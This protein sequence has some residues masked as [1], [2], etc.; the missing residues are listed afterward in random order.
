MIGMKIIEDRNTVESVEDWSRVRSPS[1][2]RRRLRYGHKQNIDIK[3]VPRK[4][5][6][7]IGDTLVMHP[8]MAAEMR[9]QLA[10]PTRGVSVETRKAETRVLVDH[11]TKDI[12]PR[13]RG[14]FV[15]GGMGLLNMNAAA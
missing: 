3:H 13:Y 11:W 5:A 6:F 1:R 7:K 12:L 15:G 8:I 2:A 14:L 10:D 4:E 9:R